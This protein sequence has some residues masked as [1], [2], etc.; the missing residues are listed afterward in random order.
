MDAEGIWV[1]SPPA[2]TVVA[3]TVPWLE[4]GLPD[5]A[6]SRFLMSFR[7]P[8]ALGVRLYGG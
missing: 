2:G 5:D 8:L 4:P 6:V 7:I 1:K 3:R